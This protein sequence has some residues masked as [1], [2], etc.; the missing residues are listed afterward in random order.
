M[1]SSESFIERVI[2]GV[3]QSNNTV[4]RQPPPVTIRGAQG[5][6][7][8]GTLGG[9]SQQQQLV[10]NAQLYQGAF[11]GAAQRHNNNQGVPSRLSQ[12]PQGSSLQQNIFMNDSEGGQSQSNIFAMRSNSLLPQQD[13][14]AAEGGD[15]LDR[16]MNQ[17]AVGYGQSLGGMPVNRTQYGFQGQVQLPGF[18]VS[19]MRQQ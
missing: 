10:G 18:P 14:R 16:L 13:I 5:P 4:P 8:A 7:R 15:I 3:N 1:R 9:P 2:S 11:A 12:Y 6:N 19:Y 17:G